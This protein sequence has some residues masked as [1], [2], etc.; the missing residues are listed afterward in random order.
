MLASDSIRTDARP[1]WLLAAI[2][3]LVACSGSEPVA[4]Q[5]LRLER[6]GKTI[7]SLQP[8]DFPPPPGVPISPLRMSE[9]ASDWRAPAERRG[10]K[11]GPAADA[12]CTFEFKASITGGGERY[13]RLSRIQ[14]SHE[15]LDDP[16]GVRF[17]WRLT[18]G[19]ER[20]KYR[21]YLGGGPSLTRVEP[22]FVDARTGYYDYR[23]GDRPQFSQM[24]VWARRT[25][26][27]KR[28]DG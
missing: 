11:S 26:E 3:V 13:G 23:F 25:S 20:C 5:E 14:L 27:E 21:I 2:T 18:D 28:R 6:S 24:I 8:E 16:Q 4:A 7:S 17:R 19:V 12:T 1:T 22:T 15:P 10:K 9:A